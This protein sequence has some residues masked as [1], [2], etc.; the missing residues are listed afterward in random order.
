MQAG[1]R[2]KGRRLNVCCQTSSS[3]PHL[4]FYERQSLFYQSKVYARLLHRM[5]TLLATAHHAG[6]GTLKAP[7]NISSVLSFPES[8]FRCL[9]PTDVSYLSH[10]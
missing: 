9:L 4:L 7:S 1:L 6:K 3:A 8:A 10:T 2:S 5:L